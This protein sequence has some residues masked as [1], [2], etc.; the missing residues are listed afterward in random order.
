MKTNSNILFIIV[1]AIGFISF[2]L[3]WIGDSYRGMSGYDLVTSS[4]K[5]DKDAIFLFILPISFLLI[6]FLKIAKNIPNTL[7]KLSEILPMV[8]ILIVYIN[9]FGSGSLEDLKYLIDKDIFEILGIGFILT[10]LSG[11]LLIFD[12]INKK[13]NN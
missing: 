6:I 12:P 10:I 1:A 3:P 8:I 4:Q 13:Y 7:I 11:I 2:F 9:T 5:L